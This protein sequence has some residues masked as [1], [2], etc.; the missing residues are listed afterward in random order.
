MAKRALTEVEPTCIRKSLEP[1]VPK[2]KQ[3]QP[4]WKVIMAKRA[5]TEVEPTCI[6]KSLEPGV[7]KVR[8]NQPK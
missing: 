4:A 7:L 2:V 1:G 6:R 8:Q 3:N 5:L